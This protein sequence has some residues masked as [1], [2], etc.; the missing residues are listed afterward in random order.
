MSATAQ[1]AQS[2][3]PTHIQA[4]GLARAADGID[5]ELLRSTICPDL[6]DPEFRLFAE[7]C[8]R[9]RLDPFRKQIYAIVRHEKNGRRR[10]THQTAID[11]FR[12][13]A[14]RSGKYEGQQGP[15]WC[16]TDGLWRD[17]WLG[18]A[19]PAAAKVGVFRAGFREPL[20]AVARWSSYVV[21]GENGWMWKKMP[22]GQIAKCAEALA[23]RK[24]FPEDLGD[25]YSSDEMQQADAKPRIE[26]AK[27]SDEAPAELAEVSQKAQLASIF[28]ER[29]DR[30]ESKEEL[31]GIM[32]EIAGA[33]LPT[34]YS[35]G[36]KRPCRERLR[37][38]A[39]ATAADPLENNPM[40]ASYDVAP[41]QGAGS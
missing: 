41:N 36:L 23:L 40:P 2:A 12:L 27:S 24:G 8:K 14:E 38:F 22:D 5:L 21:E 33:G 32:Q 9:T 39:K 19:V 17:V 37:E 3:N 7:V 16:A 13:I 25:L 11:G 20:W 4:P 18:S 15:F 34:N 31:T 35:E 10:V 28:L 26:E 29:I 6:T 30:A 1:I